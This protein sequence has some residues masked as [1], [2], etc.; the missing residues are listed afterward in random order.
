VSE[1]E[2]VAVGE[3][4]EERT[5]IIVVDDNQAIGDILYEKLNGMGYYCCVVGSADDALARLRER[6][7]D[8]V[9]LDI[10][11]PRKSGIDLLKDLKSSRLDTAVIIISAVV[12]LDTI[13]Q[14]KTLWHCDYI[15][16]PFNLD[17]VVFS[18]ERAIADK[19]ISRVWRRMLGV[20]PRRP[21]ALF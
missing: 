8:I 17:E 20:K 11:L 4:R 14:A 19:Y 13:L 10:K 16:K 2:I 9:L 18:I 1:L 5:A 3:N 12:D 7:F 15:I 21:R 6:P